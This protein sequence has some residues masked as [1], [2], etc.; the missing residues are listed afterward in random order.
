MALLSEMVHR[1]PLLRKESAAFVRAVI[2]QV[3]R[4]GEW[5]SRVGVCMCVCMCVCVCVVYE[6]ECVWTHAQR[7]Y[8]W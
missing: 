2:M 8:C 5:A 6:R 1:V 7:A 3:R 4:R